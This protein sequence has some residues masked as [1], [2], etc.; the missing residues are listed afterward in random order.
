VAGRKGGTPRVALVT[1]GGR[2]IGRGIS[3]NLAA[4]GLDVAVVY[5]SDRQAAEAVS[6]EIR[7]GGRKAVALGCDL[8]D[9]DAARRVASRTVDELGR[10]DVVVCNAAQLVFK[11]FLDTT[12]QEFDLQSDTNARGAFFVAQAAARRMIEQGDGGRIIFITSDAAVRTY[13][14][15]S[16][17]SMTKAALKNLTEMLAKELAPYDITV[18][19]VAPGTTETD[20]NR[21]ALADPE[22]RR[23]LLGSILLGRPG[24][25]SD[26]AHAVAFLASPAAAFITGATLAVDGGAA[27]H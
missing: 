22:K 8:A 12:V 18:N 27:V 5:R 19:A 15:L 6:L 7:N 23:M 20:M 1:G 3:L 25:P 14:G 16:A 9:P 10:L 17:Y 21:S 26:V 13:P 24:Q 11:P 4:Q 2:G